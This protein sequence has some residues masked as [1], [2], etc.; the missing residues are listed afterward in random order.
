MLDTDHVWGIGGNQAWVW[1][2]FLRGHNP[3]FMDPYDGSVLGKAF[4]PQWE[5]VRRSLGFARR[6]AAR[7]DLASM[8]PHN[9]LASTQYCLADPASEYLVYLPTGGKATV[10]LSKGQG[11]FAV[12]W[13]ECSTGESQKAET[14]N[15][16]AERE[17]TAPFAGDAVLHL[18]T[19]TE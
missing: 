16:G 18:F 12:E 6:L 7:A 8:T 1:K 4:D 14:V 10:D 17:F 15:G 13:L 9:A 11:N 3:L 2:S 5:P 19:K